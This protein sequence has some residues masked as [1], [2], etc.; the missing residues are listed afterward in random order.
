MALK[1]ESEYCDQTLRDL[2]TSTC[3]EASRSKRQSNANDIE[4]HE[5]LV[6]LTRRIEHL[7][8]TISR[9]EKKKLELSEAKPCYTEKRV[10]LARSR[11]RVTNCRARPRE[12]RGTK[13][14]E[15]LVR[16]NDAEVASLVMQ[17]FRIKHLPC[18]L[19]GGE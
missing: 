12:E 4:L 15:L 1:H 10:R 6:E 19:V 18:P 8:C 11:A 7:F 17:H 14:K 3:F 13:G 2:G 5:K 9:E 16:N